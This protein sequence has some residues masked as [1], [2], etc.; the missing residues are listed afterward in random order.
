MTTNKKWA[1]LIALVIVFSM[2]LTA[3][4]PTPETQVETVI[5]TVQVEVT[6]I[7]EKE[8][9]VETV[10]ETI[11]ETVEVEVPKEVQV[12]VTAV[13]EPED[14]VGGWLDM[15]IFVEEPNEQAAITRLDVGEIDVYAYTVADPDAFEAVKRNDK[16]IYTESVGSY[17]EIFF[18]PAGPVF[19]GTGALNPF[20]NAK[21]REAMNWLVDRDYI[22]DE[23]LG[24]LGRLKLFP[25]VTAFPDYARYADVAASLEAQYAHDPD[26]AQK[27]ITQEMEAMGAELVDGK[28]RYEGEPVVLIFLI[29]TEDER[30][31]YGDYVANL[32]EDVGFTVDRQYKTSAEASPIW[33]SSDPND[34]LWHLYT[35]GWITTSI[36]RDQGGNFDAFY[37]PRGSPWPA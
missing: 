25:L 26:K 1:S 37:T 36:N 24:G 6:K 10:V 22:I 9:K 17:N 15:V 4:G 29:R 3:C 30:L 12:E 35:G 8:G 34:G 18:N 31:E 11:V 13:P 33:I 5:Q 16:L 19:D 23:I 27:V 7:V 14:R 21:I 28:W 20:N 32:L 2:M